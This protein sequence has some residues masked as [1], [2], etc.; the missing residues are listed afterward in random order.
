VKRQPF[1]DWNLYV[2]EEATDPSRDVVSFRSRKLGR[3]VAV[4]GTLAHQPS[5]I[6]SA[7]VAAGVKRPGVLDFTVVKLDAPGSA[8]GVFTKSLCPSYA[9][10]FDKETL[11]D[12][13][14]QALVVVSKN[15]NVFT[16]AGAA[17]TRTLARWVADEL[18]VDANDIVLSCTG[19][20]GV[21]LPMDRLR[22]AVTGIAT[23]LEPN[24]LD[25]TARA[26][27]TTDRG[28]KVCSVRVGDV[29]V[30]AMAKGAGMIEPNMATMLVYFF[31]NADLDGPALKEILTG[32]V[33]RTF[34]AI[35][36]DSDTSTSDSV[37]AFST[38]AVPVDADGRADF[39]DAVRCMSL[40]LA[41]DIVSQSEG[42]TKL[43][44]CTV[45][46]DSSA[47][48]AKVMAKKIVN[49]PLV[50]T[51]IHGGDP[52]WGR[53]IMAIGKP[54]ERL[55][56]AAIAPSDVVVEMMGQVLFSRAHPVATDLDA[57]A[58]S[59]KGSSRVT[60]DVRIGEGRHAATV[61]GC[62]LG[63]GYVDINAEYMT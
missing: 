15:A 40:K 3:D 13:R 24:A 58:R 38:R 16:P 26:I 43:I 47:R 17:D 62:D 63:R 11:S 18:R 5:G 1:D 44:E 19:V 60:I 61:W 39:A 48:D 49:S 27:L 14:A 21:P 41:R 30:C 32:A 23:A 56:I 10:Q 22:A 37:V 45:R 25:G 46:I 6:R 59:L 55:G 7:A 4:E 31:T 20:I 57:L 33:E 35:S 28:P 2:Q 8:A 52:N 34:N 42:A 50:K 51:A 54:D 12:G 53:L 36:V 29:V 9:V